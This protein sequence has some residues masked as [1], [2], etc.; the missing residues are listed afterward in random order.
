MSTDAR[1]E[2]VPQVDIDEGIFKYVLIKVY[3]KE[4]SDGSEAQKTIVRYENGNQQKCTV[5]E[6]SCLY[7]LFRGFTRAEWHGK[8]H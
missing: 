4:N 1:L 5:K 8:L 7:F 6:I 3:G 2:A